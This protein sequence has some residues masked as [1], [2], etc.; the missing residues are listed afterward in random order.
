MLPG[1]VSEQEPGVFVPVQG[2]EA[3]AE[4]PALPERAVA[5]A[6]ARQPAGGGGRSDGPGAV[7]EG[8]PEAP[9]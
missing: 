5:G 8:V 6:R 2:V 7:P 4:L 9:G 1:P 3:Q